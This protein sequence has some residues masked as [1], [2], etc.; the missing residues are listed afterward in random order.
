MKRRTFIK[1]ATGATLAA[2]AVTTL[3]QAK[4]DHHEGAHGQQILGWRKYVIE[5]AAQRQIVDRFLRKAAIPALNR[6][7][8]KPIGVFYDND[9]KDDLSIYT[10]AP[11][12]SLEAYFGAHERLAADSE[13]LENAQEYLSTE[14][15]SP[16]YKRIESSIMKA[17]TGF[18]Q[19]KAPLS[20]DRI[21]E[22]RIYESH[23]EIK[24]L[25][26]VEMFNEAELDI[27]EKVDLKGVFYGESLAGANLPNL[28]YMIAYKNMDERKAAWSRFS[29]HP[30]W[31]VLKKNDRYKDTVSNIEAKFLVPASYSQI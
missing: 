23:N 30:D 27:F 19:V 13:F 25:L 18:P 1:T 14:K 8:V 24:A 31:Q 16:A 28:T 20:G 17:F 4:A 2:A 11:F 21:F 15:D 3:N 26:K 22:L 9:N 6:L 29:K 5:T 7:G 10:I 12:A